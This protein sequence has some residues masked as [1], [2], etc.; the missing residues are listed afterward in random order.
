MEKLYQCQEVYLSW[1]YSLEK[2]SLS[3]TKRFFPTASFL[4]KHLPILL[5]TIDTPHLATVWL[6]SS[7]IKYTDH[8]IDRIIEWD[9]SLSEAEGLS[10]RITAFRLGPA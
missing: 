3:S 8:A 5:F 1:F 9:R 6:L 4:T 2:L 7:R 10:A